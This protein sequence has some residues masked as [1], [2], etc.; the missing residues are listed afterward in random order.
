MAKHAQIKAGTTTGMR[1]V[2]LADPKL[3]SF[4]IRNRWSLLGYDNRQQ[5]VYFE[6]RPKQLKR[7]KIWYALALVPVIPIVVTA[8]IHDSPVV[9]QVEACPVPKLGLAKIGQF[10][11]LRRVKLGGVTQL[12][13]S[14]QCEETYSLTIDTVKNLIV[15]LKKL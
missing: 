3:G 14:T 6:P 1:K 2:S 15:S 4:L 12:T 9:S 13:V 8:G 10:E 7:L 5:Y 11:E